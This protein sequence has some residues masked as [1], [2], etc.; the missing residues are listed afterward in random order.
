MEVK[1]RERKNTN[2]MKWDGT[3]ARFGEADLF[4]LWVADMDFEV[5]KC[6]KEELAAYVEQGTFGYYLP[7]EEYSSAFINWEKNYHKYE[8]QKEW[9]RFA[10]GVV[11][12]FNWMVQTLTK[13]GDHVLI[14]PPVYFPF[15]KAIVNNQR[16]LVE[17]ILRRTE[18]SYELDFADFE[19][20]IIDKQ[21]KLFIFCSPHNPVGKVWKR[22]ELVKIL[23]IC[24]KHQV[25]V[26]SD[27][28][29]Q[30][31]IL[32]G[33]EQ[34]ASATV[35][36]YDDI[37]VTL[38]SATKT[39]NLAGCQNSFLIIPKEEIRNKYDKFTKEIAMDG[40]NAFGYIAVRSAYENG[41]SWLEELLK[42][43]EKN[44]EV[45]KKILTKAYP[46]I[47]ISDLQG[48]YLSWIDLGAYVKPEEMV[49]FIQNKCKL[50][51]N[52]GSWFGGNDSGS[53]IRVNLATKEENII[54]AANIIVEQL[55]IKNI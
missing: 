48:T 32:K 31:L 6:V 26:L 50:A 21:V 45:M 3:K 55:K 5:P 13:P 42:I 30:D 38:T 33:N 46:N 18:T 52:F 23:D 27:E 2:S 1:Y 14:T 39:F 40:G 37:L 22:E 51:V 44:Y 29:H 10:P 41:R 53:C 47:W 28:I 11:Q 49:D 25:Y 9:I 7:P 20:K 54:K 12:G 35:G 24:K 34:I 17:S 36:D 8:V 15:E 4:P 43:I 19:Q 16:K